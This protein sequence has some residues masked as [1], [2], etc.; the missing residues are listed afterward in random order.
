MQSIY[1]RLFELLHLLFLRKLGYLLS[2]KTIL[3][4]LCKTFNASIEQQ[5]II[6]AFLTELGDILYAW[7]FI[8]MIGN[9]NFAFFILIAVELRNV[10]VSF[11]V[12][13]W[14]I[15]CLSD[16]ILFVFFWLSEIDQEKIC[17]ETYWQLLGF[18]CD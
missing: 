13:S 6:I 3:Y 10:F 15:E 16:V 17:F 9:Y 7:F 4:L 1:P 5:N 14:E 8:K 12:C 18:Y 2:L 11:D